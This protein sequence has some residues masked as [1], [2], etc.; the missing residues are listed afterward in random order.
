MNGRI[1]FWSES[2]FQFSKPARLGYIVNK[3]VANRSSKLRESAG[4]W[5]V[6]HSQPLRLFLIR[7]E[8]VID[9]FCE[10][11]MKEKLVQRMLSFAMIILLSLR[12]PGYGYN[13]IQG[14]KWHRI[15]ALLLLDKR[16]QSHASSSTKWYRVPSTCKYWVSCSQ[17]LFA[18]L[19]R[20]CQ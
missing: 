5:T 19:A 17:S 4:V 7:I 2:I 3:T 8:V 16:H 10:C 11:E 13:A 1:G 6:G 9:L 14:Q 18:L 20:R 15:Q 12:I